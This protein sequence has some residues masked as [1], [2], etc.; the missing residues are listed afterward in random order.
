MLK[1]L[2]IAAS[3]V[4]LSFSSPAMAESKKAEGAEVSGPVFVE[5]DRLTVP[6]INQ[7]GISQTVSM[8]ITVEAQDQAMADK[9]TNMKPRLK[10]AFIQDM[11]GAFSRQAALQGGVIKVDV[12]KARLN[13][14]SQ[15]VMGP[16]IISDVL[17]QAVMQRRV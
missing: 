5:L 14:V 9:I 15:K 4:V 13:K 11:Y 6:I 2:L 8:L 10:D 1:Y 7:N 3:F 17:L 16:D 12:I